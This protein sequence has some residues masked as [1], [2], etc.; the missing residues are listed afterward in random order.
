MVDLKKLNARQ[1]AII[2]DLE[3]G[4]EPEVVTNPYSQRSVTLEPTAVALHDYIKGCEWLG[5]T[6]RDFSEALLA[7]RIL[8]PD[9]YYILLD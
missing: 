3:I 9:A 6:G 4:T 8:W 1:R 2:A 5:N 7:F